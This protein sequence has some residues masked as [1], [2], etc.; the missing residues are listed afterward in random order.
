MTQQR[1]GQK[2]LTDFQRTDTDDWPPYDAYGPTAD[3]PV[4][5]A[6]HDRRAKYP[7]CPEDFGGFRASPRADHHPDDC[8]HYVTSDDEPDPPF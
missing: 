8:D 3:E 2:R 1:L 7:L 5:P 6:V 4:P